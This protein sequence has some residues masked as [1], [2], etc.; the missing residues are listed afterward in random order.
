MQFPSSTIPSPLPLAPLP[1][2]KPTLPQEP[3]VHIL[4]QAARTFY[5]DLPVAEQEAWLA[6]VRPHAYAT[7]TAK[8]PAA[9]WKEIPTSYLVCE[10]DLAIPVFAQEGMTEMARGMGGEVEVTRV[11]S[12][13]SPFLSIPEE[14]V[15]WLRGVAGEVL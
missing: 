6:K 13:H 11:K 9:A 8:A 10:N 14:V 12:G 4:P 2:S 1:I 15:R 3:Y 7:M 5:N